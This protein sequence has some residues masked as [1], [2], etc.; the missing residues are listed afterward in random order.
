MFPWDVNEM[1]MDFFAKTWMAWLL[2]LI[3]LNGL[4]QVSKWK[5]DEKLVSIIVKGVTAFI[6]KFEGL[7]YK[8]EVKV[9]PEDY[10]KKYGLPKSR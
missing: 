5:W 10:Q 3:I 1:L 7:I 2:A 8:E 4:A 9:Q 6:P